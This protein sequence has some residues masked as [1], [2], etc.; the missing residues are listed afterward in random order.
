ML[1]AMILLTIS[2]FTVTMFTKPVAMSA[3]GKTRWAVI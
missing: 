2:Q 1:T 3:L